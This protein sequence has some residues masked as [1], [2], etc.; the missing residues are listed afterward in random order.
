MWVLYGAFIYGAF[1]G[2]MTFR[3]QWWLVHTLVHLVRAEV[4][5]PIVTAVS[6]AFFF[7]A[8]PYPHGPHL[9]YVSVVIYLIVFFTCGPGG[10]WFKRV[11]K[12]VASAMTSVQ[13]AV[14]RRE[15]AQA[16]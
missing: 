1:I 9:Q 5:V 12:W 15:I 6:L 3:L 8:I 16:A 11:G 2:W 4:E 10:R 7:C 14:W 13:A